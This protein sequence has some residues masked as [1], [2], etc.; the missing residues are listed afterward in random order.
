[1]VCKNSF[2]EE[3]GLAVNQSP[4]KSGTVHGA[5]YRVPQS[6]TLVQGEPTR[7]PHS[8][9]EVGL[10]VNQSPTKSGTVH[11]ALYR[12]PQSG[13]L[14]QGEPTRFPRSAEEVGLEPTSGFLHRYGLAIRCLTNSA[15]SSF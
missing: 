3:V 4:T 1:M 8:A 9:E 6:G 15:H 14:V 7:F 2:A 11:G 10:A 12:V 13:T 5:L